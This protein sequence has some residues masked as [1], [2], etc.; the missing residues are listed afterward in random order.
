MSGRPGVRAE[1]FEMGAVVAG[2]EPPVR[3]PARG[4]V[5]DVQPAAADHDAGGIDAVQR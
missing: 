5:L 1:R 4:V 2:Q 3:L